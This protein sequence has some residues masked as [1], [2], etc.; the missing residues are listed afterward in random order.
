MSQISP[1]EAEEITFVLYEQALKVR[2]LSGASCL[3]VVTKKPLDWARLR[4]VNKD[5]N[6]IIAASDEGSFDDPQPGSSVCVAKPSLDDDA[7][8]S[9]HSQLPAIFHDDDDSGDGESEYLDNIDSSS[10][11]SFLRDAFTFGFH[12][13]RLDVDTCPINERIQNAILNASAAGLIRSTDRVVVLYS[14]FQASMLDSIAVMTPGT[15]LDQL[16]L[17]DLRAIADHIPWKTLRVA[18]DLA[19][20]IGR[21][22]REQKK[23]G[24]LLV[25]GDSKRVLRHSS[26]AGFDPVKGY[27]ASER[28][29]H[30]PK[31]REGLKEIAQLD[32]AFVIAQNGE[33]KAACRI[34]STH[35]ANVSL[36]KGLGSRH[37]AAAAIS[38]AT[39]AVAIAVSESSGTVRVFVNGEPKICIES[40]DNR[41][42]Q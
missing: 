34:L 1:K 37:W 4:E 3:F 22:G 2:E 30:D 36:S 39:R 23:V 31:T 16:S 38:K 18:I 13:I 32:G 5:A 6:V 7:R 17:K 14:N 35:I 25:V 11:S 29:I 42:G 10:V 12:T 15:L 9:L 21:E 41:E 27:M 20:E 19:I 8:N 33:V 26:S 40:R 28:N 24:T